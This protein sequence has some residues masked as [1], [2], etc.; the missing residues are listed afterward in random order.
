M[1]SDAMSGPDPRTAGI[2]EALGAARDAFH[3][4]AVG[5]TE[6]I[7][8]MLE[9]HE[10]ATSAGADLLA[11]ELGPFAVGR[12]DTGALATLL[13]GVETVPEAATPVVRRALEVLSE[14]AESGDECDDGAFSPDGAG[15][16]SSD[17][18]AEFRSGA[19]FVDVPSGGDLRDVVR[20]ALTRAG[21][22]FGA[23]RAAD[24]A[25]TGRFLPEQE[26]L[27][28]GLPFRRWTPRE[29]RL[30]PPLVV[31]VDA[32]DLRPSGLGD[33]LDGSQTVVLRVDGPAPPPAALA[34]LVTPGVM[35]LQTT[36]PGAVE[37]L[38]RFDGPAVAAVFEKD[39]EIVPFLHDPRGGSLPWERITLDGT[40]DEV[41]ARFE[42]RRWKERSREDDIEHL[43][44]LAT[45]PAAPAAAGGPAGTEEAPAR[46]VATADRL[47]AWL[48][49]RTDLDGS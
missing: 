38:V 41:R 30:A 25:R 4:A 27:F 23:A 21:R 11:A 48:L 47:A 24:L 1:P 36:D 8:G 20:D 49:A 9:V 44:E 33:F 46:D 42:E 2:L 43:V 34:R 18:G 3:S 15:A 14:V 32:D 40:P 7:E 22:L 35:V 19:A 17:P 28:D 10:R 5:L 39:A 45:P 26:V 37:P 13:A 29:R 6:E 16:T 12:I 31:R